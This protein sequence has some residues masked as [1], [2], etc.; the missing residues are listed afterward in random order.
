[1]N[2]QAKPQDIWRRE[3]ANHIAL[4]ARLAETPAQNG[5]WRQ[6][7]HELKKACACAGM[8]WMGVY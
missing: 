4:A 7:C 1:M 2:A 6:V 8:R 3:A 5:V